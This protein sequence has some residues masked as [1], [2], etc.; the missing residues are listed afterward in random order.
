MNPLLINIP[1]EKITSWEQLHPVFTELF[2]ADISTSE[3]FIHWLRKLSE[4]E[5]H[6][7]EDLAW[8]YIRMT[9]DTENKALKKDYLDFVSNIQPHIAPWEDKLNRKLYESPFK[10]DFTSEEFRI[11]FRRIAK[12]IELFRQENIPLFVELQTN[13]QKYASISGAMTVSLQGNILTLQQAA[14]FL[15]SPEAEIRKEAFE[16]IQARRLQDKDTLDT[17]LNQLISKRNQVAKNAGY[18]NFRDYMHVSLARFDYSIEDC[19]RFH[20]AVE[21][22][23]VP[24]NRQ[25]SE[26]RKKL[27]GGIQKPW[28]TEFD[29]SGKPALK[30][31]KDGKDLAEKTIRAFQR[32]DPFFGEVISAMQQKGHLDLD[33]RIGKAPGGYNYPLAVTGYPFIFMNAASSQRDLETMVHEGGHAIH[34][35]LTK[36]LMLQAFKDCPSE[37]AELA[38]MSMELISMSVWDEFYTDPED[39]RRAQA[40]QLEGVIKTLPWIA[41]IDAFQHWLYTHPGHSVQERLDAWTDISERFGSGTVDWSGYET[42]RKYG[43]QKQLHIYEVPFYYIEYGFAQLGAIAV[44]RNYLE[45]PEKGLRQYK[46]ALSLGYTRP[47]PEIYA[48]A[49]AGFRFSPEYVGELFDFVKREYDKIKK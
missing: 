47:I 1:G 19:F 21:K 30:P 39:L 11:Y 12:D 17:L 23:V 16:A 3:H 38:S 46:E 25:L 48:A 15:K 40:E 36:D 37:V 42:E 26:E 5:S 34:S 24:L 29:T 44:W 43:W 10:N 22:A 9:C 33:S 20:D 14:V 27:L 2:Q 49:G 31:F 45:N 41:S 13:A 18:S 28:D 6:I 32:L 4:L 35:V 8:R 7:S